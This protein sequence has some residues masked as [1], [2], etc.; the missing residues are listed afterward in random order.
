MSVARTAQSQLQVHL[1][2]NDLTADPQVFI[3][4]LTD[5][6]QNLAR[7]GKNRAFTIRKFTDAATSSD[8]ANTLTILDGDTEGNDVVNEE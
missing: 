2:T 1:F 7:I 8:A 4:N 5:R 6:V 3:A